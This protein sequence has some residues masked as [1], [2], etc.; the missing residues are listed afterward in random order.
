VWPFSPQAFV[1]LFIEYNILPT[2]KL[3]FDAK[4]LTGRRGIS[5]QFLYNDHIGLNDLRN[6]IERDTRVPR[7]LEVSLSGTF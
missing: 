2:V 5:T 3:R 6:R 4:Q 1:G 7:E